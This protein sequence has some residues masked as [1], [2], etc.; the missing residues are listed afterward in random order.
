MERISGR[1]GSGHF[2]LILSI[3][4]KQR[5]RFGTL[6]AAGRHCHSSED[7]PL[8]FSSGC[9]CPTQ[10]L[11]PSDSLLLS[12]KFL[13]INREGQGKDLAARAKRGEK[14]RFRRKDAKNRGQAVAGCQSRNQE[15]RRLALLARSGEASRG[16]G[17][18][19]G[20][21][22]PPDPVSA[23]RA[24]GTAGQ[25]RGQTASLHA[26]T[27]R[28]EKERGR[29]GASAARKF[30]SP[31]FNPPPAVFLFRTG[32]DVNRLKFI[33]TVKFYCISG[34]QDLYPGGGAGGPADSCA[35]SDFPV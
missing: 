21:R 26:D 11:R 32:G 35:P 22:R 2:C 13:A 3:L 25:V 8:G 18:F 7:R 6:L 30:V 9:P 34:P 14:T 33:N 4:G 24:A 19:S 27:G 28:P 15:A 31:S 5:R 23:E 12:S 16:L 17:A 20:G 1:L 10:P 29:A